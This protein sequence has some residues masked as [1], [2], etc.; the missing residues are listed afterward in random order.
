MPAMASSTLRGLY[1]GGISSTMRGSPAGGFQTAARTSANPPY[2]AWTSRSFGSHLL[3][4]PCT[5]DRLQRV[6]RRLKMTTSEAYETRL[7]HGALLHHKT[8]TRITTGCRHSRIRADDD[9]RSCT[10]D[11]LRDRTPRVSSHHADAYDEQD[12]PMRENQKGR[13]AAHYAQT[14]TVATRG[15]LG[16]NRTTRCRRVLKRWSC[17]CGAWN[18]SLSPI[19][20][21]RSGIPTA[22]TGSRRRRTGVSRR[23]CG[24]RTL[25]LDTLHHVGD[26]HAG[27]E[28]QHIGARF[29]EQMVLLV[30]ESGVTAKK[31]AGGSRSPSVPYRYP[32]CDFGAHVRGM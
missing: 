2:C 25:Q 16:E 4:C 8:F 23:R 30:C 22:V 13:V 26:L 15:R 31:R 5:V 1:S 19:G 9:S 10:F 6:S 21:W 17:G 28:P 24:C 20:N 3:Q 14:A 11:Q 32:K 29:L 12:R 27:V 18:Q 7:V